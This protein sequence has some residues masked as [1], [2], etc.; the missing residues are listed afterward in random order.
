MD[1]LV[2]GCGSIGTRHIGN[3]LDMD[4]ISTVFGYD[5]D[6]TTAQRVADEHGIWTTT[7]SQE[8][9]GRSPE[10]ALI[11]TP[12]DTHIQLAETA[13]AHDAH[14]FIE[15]PLSNTLSGIPEFLERTAASS[16]IVMIGCNMRFHP[17]V[18]QMKEW[19]SA[20]EIGRIEYARLRYGNHLSSWRP[21]DH[22][23]H[24]TAQ[25]EQGGGIVLDGIHE[26]DLLL[27]LLSDPKTI[28]C[29]SG[30][31][32]DLEVNVEDTAELLFEGPSQLGSVH[33]DFIRP[34]RARTYE[35]IGTEGLIQW[36]ARGKNPEKSKIELYRMNTETK[37][38]KSYSLTGNEMFVN[39]MS[40][41]FNCIQ[42]NSKPVVDETKGKDALKV[43]LSAKEVSQSG[44]RQYI[45]A[46]NY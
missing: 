38:S 41:F 24:Y 7:D 43:A 19:L 29:A 1:V 9:W 16:S 34:E 32:S 44:K 22:S 17:P 39:E 30:T 46:N 3:L 40:H 36:E 5:S 23:E 37:K 42:T 31:Y 8:A 2:V 45:E 14:V 4:Y 18:A 25:E 33:I 12:P 13:L 11:C 21:G 10:V 15:K 26:I 27:E 35:L 20:G 6:T 28:Q